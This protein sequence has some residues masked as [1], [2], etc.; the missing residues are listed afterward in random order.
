MNSIK[1]RRL[2][3]DPEYADLS[4]ELSLLEFAY[5]LPESVFLLSGGVSLYFA[6]M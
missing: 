2:L 6:S 5:E 3:L 1:E 4:E